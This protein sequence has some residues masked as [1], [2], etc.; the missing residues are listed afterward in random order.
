[1]QT[2]G[3]ILT[4][5]KLVFRLTVLRAVTAEPRTCAVTVMLNGVQVDSIESCDS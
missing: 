1:M 5:K 4:L 3:L 2:D